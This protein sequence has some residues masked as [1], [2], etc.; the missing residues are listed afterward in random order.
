M[1][2]LI[3]IPEELARLLREI[4]EKESISRTE[5]IRRAI[6]MYTAQLSAGQG[7]E[8]AFGLWKGRKRDALKIEQSLRKE[9][10][11]E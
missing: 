3:N 4:C 9:W 2:A 6:A 11:R 1:K 8:G 7:G 5:A 10:D